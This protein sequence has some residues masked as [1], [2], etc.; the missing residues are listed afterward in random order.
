MKIEKMIIKK[1]ETILPYD[2]NET[3]QADYD[4]ET[5]TYAFD[6]D[7]LETLSFKDFLQHNHLGIMQAL[8]WGMMEDGIK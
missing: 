4:N 3:F 7:D 5:V 8:V 6:G 1:L 2:F